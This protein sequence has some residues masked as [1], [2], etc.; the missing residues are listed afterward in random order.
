MNSHF[1]TKL[2][3]EGC[4]KVH[5]WSKRVDLFSSD[6]IFIPVCKSHHWTLAVVDFRAKRLEHYDSLGKGDCEI[7]GPIR[8]WLNYEHCLRHDAPFD[9]G[10]LGWTLAHVE[11]CASQT[12]GYDCGVYVCEFMNCISG[13]R[14]I[15]CTQSQM[16]DIRRRIILELAASQVVSVRGST[17]EDGE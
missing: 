6:M 1:Y 16:T 11:C 14:P 10:G 7:F 15:T 13:G 2:L 3:R 17:G 9:V 12:N 5:R 4:D 8:E